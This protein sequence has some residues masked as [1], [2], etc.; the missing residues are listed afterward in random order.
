M[1]DDEKDAE[2]LSV[3]FENERQVQERLITASTWEVR[4]SW[5]GLCSKGP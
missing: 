2:K 5:N 1:L 4:E 3:V